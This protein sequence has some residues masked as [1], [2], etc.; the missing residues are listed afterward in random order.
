MHSHNTLRNL[1]PTRS[2]NVNLIICYFIMIYTLDS[3]FN[4]YN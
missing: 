1:S 3:K 2:S 4:I